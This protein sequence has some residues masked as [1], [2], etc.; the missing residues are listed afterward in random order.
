MRA[1]QEGENLEGDESRSRE[2]KQYDKGKRAAPV[3]AELNQRF[4]AKKRGDSNMRRGRTDGFGEA[5]PSREGEI[6]WRKLENVLLGEGKANVE[7]V[8]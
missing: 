4:L 7:L 8:F 3:R 1:K 5:A 2:K 6:Q